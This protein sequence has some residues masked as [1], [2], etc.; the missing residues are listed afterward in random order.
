MCC[1]GFFEAVSRFLS[2]WS[3]V[4]EGMESDTALERRPGSPHVV[5]HIYVSAVLHI[6]DEL[7]ARVSGFPSRVPLTVLDGC[8]S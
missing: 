1:D 7:Q 8:I 5:C 4:L 6:Y 3:I 2:L